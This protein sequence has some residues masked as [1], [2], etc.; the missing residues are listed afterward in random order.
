[1]PIHNCNQPC[2][3]FNSVS[4]VQ[5]QTASD[6]TGLLSHGDRNTVTNPVFVTIMLQSSYRSYACVIEDQIMCESFEHTDTTTHSNYH[7]K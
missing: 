4:A 3:V 7:Q 5:H 6:N 2:S 1:M